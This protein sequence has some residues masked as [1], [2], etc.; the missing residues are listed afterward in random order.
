MHSAV[1]VSHTKNATAAREPRVELFSQVFSHPV[2]LLYVCLIYL[3]LCVVASTHNSGSTVYGIVLF[4]IN[5]LLC[6]CCCCVGRAG[7]GI[8]WYINDTLIPTLV[9][10][11]GK[12]YT[13]VSY[14]GDDPSDN[15]NYHPF[16]ITSSISGGRVFMDDQE[17]AV[18]LSF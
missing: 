17:K 18:S 7:W 8:T 15:P 10:Q 2:Y 3:W 14:G 11:R 16:Y 4:C 9:V 13:F 6:C 12:T 5:L 1:G